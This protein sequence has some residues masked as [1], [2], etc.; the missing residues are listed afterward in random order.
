MLKSLFGKKPPPIVTVSP[1]GRQFT[2]A[3]GQT[4]L[5]AGLLAGVGIEHD[6]KVGSCGTCKYR[7]ISGKV[8]ELSPS[9]L[10]LTGEQ[11]RAG[12]RLACQCIPKSDLEIAL[13]SVSD[14]APLQSF[15]GVISRVT[16]LTH[17]IVQ[18]D[19]Q[20]AAP[21]VYR[22]GQYADL[23]V[24]AVPGAR[25]Y[26]FASAPKPGGN[27]IISFHVR[28][29]ANGGFTGWLFGA[30]R[31]GANVNVTGPQGVF[32]LREGDT[33][34]LCIGG[35]SGLAPLK[36]IL[37][38]AFTDAVTRPV[39]LLYGARTQADLYCLEEI[40]SMRS[41]W[42]APFEFRP[43]L[44]AE[45]ANSEWRGARGLVADF[46]PRVEN[47]AQCQAYLCGPP[48]MVDAAEAILLRHGVQQQSIFADRFYDRSRPAEV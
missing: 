16:P 44:S 40:G 24:D 19:I 14:A 34:I 3:S 22:A 29:V 13:D 43:V 31:T 46:A 30:D 27:S 8:S 38:Q 6:C 41:K 23:L 15:A 12:Y 26:S 35:G 36:A 47:L 17:D 21:L 48:P 39:T 5:E 32:G 9:A 2:V 25:S 28:Q 4:M 45:P 33:P 7:L 10:A 20:L 18:L 11:L 42:K 37:E 1:G